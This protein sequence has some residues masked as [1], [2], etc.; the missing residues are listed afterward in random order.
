MASKTTLVICGGGRGDRA[1]PHA[2]VGGQVG[3]EL[4]GLA[5]VV[6]GVV[7]VEVGVSLTVGDRPECKDRDAGLL[8]V[9]VGKSEV[10]HGRLDRAVCTLVDAPA[11]AL[12]GRRAGV[13]LT[14]TVDAFTQHV[15]LLCEPRPMY[16]VYHTGHDFSLHRCKCDN[17][18]SIL[19]IETAFL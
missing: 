3:A 12:L 7:A 11:G 5:A 15:S 14:V 17:K 6:A 18:P 2:R 8:S 9:A 16:T 19:P 13:E 4:T 10:P 1:E